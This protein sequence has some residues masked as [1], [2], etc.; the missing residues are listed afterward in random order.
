MNEVKIQ[1]IAQSTASE[2]GAV[3][4]IILVTFTVGKYG[5]FTESIP[6]AQFTN[7]ELTQRLQAFAAKLPPQVQ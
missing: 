1:S 3:I 6:K 4:Q 7:A 2:N 5:P